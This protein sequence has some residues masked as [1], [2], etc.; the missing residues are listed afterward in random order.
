[1]SAGDSGVMEPLTPS[2][3]AEEVL[4]AAGWTPERQVDITEWT[5]ALRRDGVEVSPHAEAILR[6]FGRIRLGHRGRGGPSRQDFSVDPTSW[7][8]EGEHV[9]DIEAAIGHRLSPL[10]ETMGA[11][12]LGVL[13]DGAVIAEMDGDVVQIG[14]SWRDALDYLILRPAATLKLAEDYEPVDLS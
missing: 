2:P 13:D 12:M 5:D 3:K 10:G 1:M 6:K 14:R 8:G 7:L 9:R 11:A 4:R